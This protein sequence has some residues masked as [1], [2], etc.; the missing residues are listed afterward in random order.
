MD[1]NKQYKAVLYTHSEHHTFAIVNALNQATTILGEYF[2]TSEILVV[3]V[4]HDFP[5]QKWLFVQG[6]GKRGYP[7][8]YVGDLRIGFIDDLILGK[9]SGFLDQLCSQNLAS[10]LR[11]THVE[12][13]D[14]P[15]KEIKTI[16]EHEVSSWLD[17]GQWLMMGM[18]KGVWS[19][20]TYLVT[21]GQNEEKKDEKEKDE[22][23][24]KEVVEEPAEKDKEVKEDESEEESEEEESEE[25]SED[26][27]SSED[28]SSES[29]WDSDS[30]A[31]DDEKETD[32]NDESKK[33]EDFDIEILRTNWL[34]RNQKRILRF[35]ETSFERIDPSTDSVR[36]VMP[37]DSVINII[38]VDEKNVII[39]FK[40]RV[41]EDQYLAAE[42]KEN[43]MKIIETI[44]GRASEG[45]QMSIQLLKNPNENL[46]GANQ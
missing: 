35:K 30:S 42:T 5:L 40:D 38:Q 25:E 41:A 31:E 23:E 20:M 12:C 36:A 27:S 6:K 9:E 44:C 28:S 13:K 3:N 17:A 32:E 43:I 46:D 22:I 7:Q 1:T 14:E 37:Y 21:N 8:I 11:L 19:A 45:I 33:R 39:K 26:D 15:D 24:T 2:P 4:M 34:W 18:A 29:E 10:S 16:E